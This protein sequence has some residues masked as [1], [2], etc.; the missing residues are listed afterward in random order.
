MARD[1]HALQMAHWLGRCIANQYTSLTESIAFNR[2]PQERPPSLDPIAARRWAELA[3][4]PEPFKLG[5]MTSPWLHEEVA[6]RME[7]RLTF[8]R[9]QPKSWVC[10]NPL[11]AGLNVL[12]LLHKRY[13]QAV[14]HLS[15]DRKGE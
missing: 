1:G 3:L 11:R 8:I 6:R 4:G 7:D 2:M 5:S 14:G 9:L 15:A 12:A 13:P 10:W